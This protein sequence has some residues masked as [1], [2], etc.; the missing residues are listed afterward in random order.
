MSKCY[1]ITYTET[2]FIIADT[3]EEAIRKFKQ[4]TG[5]SDEDILGVEG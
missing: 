3:E 1:A 4:D 2:D 5:K